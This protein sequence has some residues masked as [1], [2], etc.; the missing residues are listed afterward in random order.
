MKMNAI[1][2]VNTAKVP[3]GCV[4]MSVAMRTC[5]SPIQKNWCRC[6]LSL[7][8]SAHM[9]KQPDTKTSEIKKISTTWVAMI[10]AKRQAIP[11]ITLMMPR[12]SMS[13]QCEAISSSVS[14]KLAVKANPV[15]AVAPFSRGVAL[16]GAF[17]LILQGQLITRID[18]AA[19]LSL[20]Y[21][22][23]V[24]ERSRQVLD[25]LMSDSLR[26]E[27]L[28]ESVEAFSSS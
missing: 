25:R 11:A 21:G 16:F 10:G 18:A 15:V 13:F 1:K 22:R 4:Y 20:Q 28:F 5:M 7:K 23:Q 24:L 2:N 8:Q 9:L 27:P 14:T 6:P 19:L 17:M 26:R 12:N 3:K